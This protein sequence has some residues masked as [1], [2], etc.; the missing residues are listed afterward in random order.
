MYRRQVA[1]WDIVSSPKYTSAAIGP[2]VRVRWIGKQEWIFLISKEKPI[3]ADQA[4]R[5]GY[6]LR[7]TRVLS[8]MY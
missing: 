4:E 5:F 8:F 6:K 1:Q 2:H 7:I 3:L